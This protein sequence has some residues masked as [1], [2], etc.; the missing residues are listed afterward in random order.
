MKAGTDTKTPLVIFH[1][2]RSFRQLYNECIG[3]ISPN[4][5][6]YSPVVSFNG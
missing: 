4:E 6:M 5:L 1:H 3:G 2:N